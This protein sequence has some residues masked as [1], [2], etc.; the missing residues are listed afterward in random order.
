MS[1]QPR[2]QV[3]PVEPYFDHTPE[4]FG[5]GLPDPLV[6]DASARALRQRTVNFA[7]KRRADMRYVSGLDRGTAERHFRWRPAVAPRGLGFRASPDGQAELVAA[8]RA[9]DISIDMDD[10]DRRITIRW[11]DA[12]SGESVVGSAIARPG[13]G[14]IV[15]GPHQRLQFDPRPIARRRPDANRAW[16]LGEAIETLPAPPADLV[17]ALDAFFA[18]STGA[19]GLLIATPERIL[20]ERYSDFGSPDRPTP[21]WSITKAITCTVIGRLIQEGWLASVHDRAL[22]PLRRDPRSIHHMITL[23]H[24]LRMRSGLGFPVCHAD[25]RETLGFE[26]SAVYQDAGDAFEAAQ[27]SIVPRYPAQSSDKSTAASMCSVRSSG[28]GSKAEGCRTTRPCT[29]CWSIGSAWRAISTPP[30]LPAI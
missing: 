17:R 22:A 29:A 23:D 16:P 3:A 10:T 7:A 8:H 6:Y 11:N 12:S 5:D 20:C 18:R 2:A 14:A 28:T 9:G 26:N 4:P 25:G 13:Y 19:Y 27:R 1:D 24:L 30:T 15:M 21:S